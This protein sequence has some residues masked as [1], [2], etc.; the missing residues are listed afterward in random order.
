ME[1]TPCHFTKC[2][3]SRYYILSFKLQFLLSKNAIYTTSVT[4]FESCSVS[5]GPYSR[6]RQYL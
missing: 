6:K 3:V 4:S 5:F 1:S 2:G